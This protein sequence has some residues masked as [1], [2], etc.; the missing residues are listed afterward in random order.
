MYALALQAGCTVQ[1]VS[2]GW[3][4]AR[5]VLHFAQ[6][7]PAALR[8]QPLPD[9]PVTYYHAPAAPHWQ[10]DEGFFCEQCLTALEFPLH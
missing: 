4:R 2:S 5:R 1:Q 6:P 10:G 3:S 9:G 8:V 7:L